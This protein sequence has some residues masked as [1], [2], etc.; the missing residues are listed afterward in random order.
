MFLSPFSAPC[1]LPLHH[2]FSSRP[3]FLSLAIR[4]G[5]PRTCSAFPPTPISRSP[6]GAPLVNGPDL[7]PS[8][9]LSRALE[10]L[11]FTRGREGAASRRSAGP[12]SRSAGP[13]RRS[14]APTT[15][16]GAVSETVWRSAISCGRSRTSVS[17][18]LD[19]SRIPGAYPPTPP[20][21]LTLTLTQPKP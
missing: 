9:P 18:I 3:S 7:A 1:L 2:C 19:L 5:P 20:L 11:P 8:L 6:C 13:P 21:N 12:S 10:M 14:A 15:T 17:I 4:P 16:S